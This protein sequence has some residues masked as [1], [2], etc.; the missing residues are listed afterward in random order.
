[1]AKGVS[2]KVFF[3]LSG[4][5]G[6]VVPTYVPAIIRLYPFWY[7]LRPDHATD[8]REGYWKENFPSPFPTIPFRFQGAGWPDTA[9]DPS[10]PS[11]ETKQLLSHEW[12]S[13]ARFPSGHQD[14]C[15]IRN[16]QSSNWGPKAGCLREPRCLFR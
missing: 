6:S 4:I 15:F 11:K 1:M 10:A 8:G 16:R 7:L 13:R 9:T 3:V 5:V 2:S 14:A 12:E